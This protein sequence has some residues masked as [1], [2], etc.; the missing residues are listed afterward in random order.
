[1]ID[2]HL[3]LLAGAQKKDRSSAGVATVCAIVSLLAAM[4]GDMRPP[5]MCFNV[6]SGPAHLFVAKEKVPGAHRAGANR[7]IAPWVNR[8]AVRAG[9]Q[10][11]FTRMVREAFDEAFGEGALSW[12]SPAPAIGSSYNNWMLHPRAHTYDAALL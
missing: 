10:L 8:K 3:H 1:M 5:T 4:T 2:I 12:R 6:M 9:I 11:V 7:V